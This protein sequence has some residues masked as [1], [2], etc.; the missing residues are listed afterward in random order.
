MYGGTTAV[1]TTVVTLDQHGHRLRATPFRLIVVAAVGAAGLIASPADPAAADTAIRHGGIDR[2]ETSVAISQASYPQ[3]GSAKAVVIARADDFADAL[4]GTP[5]AVKVGGPLLVTGKASLDVRVREE[6]RRVLAATGDVYV[7]G[8]G[9][10]VSTVVVDGITS[11][12]FNPVRIAGTD[13]FDTAMRIAEQFGAPTLVLLCSGLSFPDA[14]SAGAAA[15]A[16]GGFV[17]LT[18]GASLPPAVAQF[19]VDHPAA[20]YIAVGGPA[21]QAAPTATPIVGATR[22]DTAVQ[23]AEQLFGAPTVVGAASGETFPDGLSGGAMIGKVGGPL[24]LVPSSTRLSPVVRSYLQAHAATV[25]SVEV[26]GGPDAVS[27]AIVR[28][29]TLSIA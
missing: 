20:Q 2:I 4:A 14:L 26:F 6:I 11:L 9:N 1:S 3:A 23:V 28:E 27:D 8:G 24:L 15:A 19:M 29:L 21:A 5:F 22:F 25:A 13:R 17:L 7:L 10:A 18:N 12:G 16:K